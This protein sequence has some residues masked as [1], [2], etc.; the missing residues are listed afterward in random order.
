MTGQEK[1]D[2]EPML[3]LFA[4]N[5]PINWEMRFGGQRSTT[6]IRKLADREMAD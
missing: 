4:P 1:S 3:A 5:T 2:L 6:L